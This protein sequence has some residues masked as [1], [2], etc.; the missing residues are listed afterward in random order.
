M[1]LIDSHGEKRLAQVQLYLSP[2]EARRVVEELNRLLAS[3]E[4]KHHFHLLSEDG[5]GELSCSVVT[6]Q[7]LAAGGYTSGE[8]K[9]L[10]GWKPKG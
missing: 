5:G 2:D 7:K 10:G 9:A 6:A 1:R 3:P 8:R 4:A